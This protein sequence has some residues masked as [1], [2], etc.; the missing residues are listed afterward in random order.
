MKG[1]IHKRIS[2]CCLLFF[3]SVFAEDN[4]FECAENAVPATTGRY[5]YN[6]DD[7]NIDHEFFL[8]IPDTY[9]PQVPGKLLLL[10]HGWGGSANE[11]TRKS[12]IVAT[13]ND[14]A[15]IVVAPTGLSDSD[16]SANSGETWSTKASWHVQGSGTGLDPYGYGICDM[17]QQT[18]SHCYHNSCECANVCPWT[19]CGDDISFVLGLIEYVKESF[20]CFHDI[21]ALG[22]SNGGMLVWDLGMNEESASV[23]T[24]V[25]TISGS[26]HA[27]YAASKGTSNSLPL[28]SFSGAKDSTIPPGTLDQVD[29]YDRTSSNG[30]N[31][32]YYY[33]PLVAMEKLWA[34]DNGCDTSSN[35]QLPV[36][37]LGDSTWPWGYV[38][39]S[40]CPSDTSWPPVVDCRTRWGGHSLNVGKIAP[41]VLDFFNAHAKNR[42]CDTFKSDS[43]CRS[44]HPR[45]QW[46]QESCSTIDIGVFLST[47]RRNATRRNA[48]MVLVAFMVLI[49]TGAYNRKRKDQI[50]RLDGNELLEQY[51]ER[52]QKKSWQT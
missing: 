15:F 5:I 4:A 12:D 16:Y 47:K 11:W 31:E 49:L 30:G 14:R 29:I 17:E 36:R 35:Q 24:A 3:A 28:I 27:G 22:E 32:V 46:L 42:P 51:K 38:C 13:A 1:A 44:E 39:N 6:D 8:H 23:F 21:Y 43:S 50:V 18:E 48:A 52:V 26:P 34:E 19:H 7:T 41:L 40:F 33:V 20:V 45:C 2:F 9:D 25:A 37:V 10:F